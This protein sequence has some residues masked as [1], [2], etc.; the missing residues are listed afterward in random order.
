MIRTLSLL[1]VF[2]ACFVEPRPPPPTAPTPVVEPAHEAPPSTRTTA[3]ACPD[4]HPPGPALCKGG[5]QPVAQRDSTSGCVTGFVCP[6]SPKP[7]ACPDVH[8]PAPGFCK[9]GLRPVARRDATSGCVTG[10]V[11]PASPKPQACPDVHPPAPGFCSVGRP[12][13]RRDATSGCVV[14]F[15]C[16]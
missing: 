5:L 7:Q 14:G 1:L 12:T 9:G 8:P 4:V 16:R 15:D 13:P 10:F 11:C 6:A 2:A 3:Q